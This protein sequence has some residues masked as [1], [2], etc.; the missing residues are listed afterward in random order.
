VLQS[1]FARIYGGSYFATFNSQISSVK[2]RSLRATVRDGGMNVTMKN[3]LRR[4]D[5]Y[6]LGWRRFGRT[7]GRCFG[8]TTVGR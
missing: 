5:D 8:T 2:S 7:N 1:R 4:G 3:K 6:E